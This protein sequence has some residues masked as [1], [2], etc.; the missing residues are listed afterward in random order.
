MSQETKNIFLIFIIPFVLGI[1]FRSLFYK[2]KKGWIVSAVAG[3][4]VLITAIINIV[5]YTHG[6]E[7]LALIL[8]Q[9]VCALI[10]SLLTGAAVRIINRKNK[11]Q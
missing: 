11:L 3:G 7:A 2:K 6:N 8:I 9:S 4:L 1:V 10:G 5:V